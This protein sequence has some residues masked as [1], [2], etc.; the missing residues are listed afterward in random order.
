MIT[1]PSNALL[2][3][4]LIKARANIKAR[5]NTYLCHAL[6]SAA[7]RRPHL[8]NASAYLRQY[9]HKKLG[10]FPYLEGW[11][12]ARINRKYGEWSL[13]AIKF[14]QTW[15]SSQQMRE[16]RLRWIDWM[17]EGLQDD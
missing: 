10:D 11:Q 14:R 3:E 15:P 4:A 2:R 6:G 5:R 7:A 17:L 9:I 8:R 12:K 16:T 13:E 1:R